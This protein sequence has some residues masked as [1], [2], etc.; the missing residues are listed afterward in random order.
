MFQRDVSGCARA[1]PPTPGATIPQGFGAVAA[2]AVPP[3]AGVQHTGARAALAAALTAKVEAHYAPFY[4]TFAKV[5]FSKKHL[6]QYTRWAP[7]AAVEV[8][9]TGSTK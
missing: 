3:V 2:L 8:M 9:V 4:A 7:R 5:P 6:A 1:C